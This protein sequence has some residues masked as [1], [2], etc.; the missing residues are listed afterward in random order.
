MAQAV[1]AARRK[2]YDAV[3]TPLLMAINPDDQV[4]SPE[5][6]R[7]IAMRW[8]GPVQRVNLAQGPDDDAMGHIMAGDVFS[9]GQ[10]AGLVDK[11]LAW[12]R[13]L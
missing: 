3:Q 13:N 1:R 7:R 11:I 2:G 6:A 12:A 8:A 9:P 10:T 5:A 4:I